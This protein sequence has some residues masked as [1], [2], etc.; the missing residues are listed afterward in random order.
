[1]SM[2]W[3]LPGMRNVGCEHN[4]GRLLHE[5]WLV[6]VEDVLGDCNQ[7][8]MLAQTARAQSSAKTDLRLDQWHDIITPLPKVF[9]G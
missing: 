2:S 4:L 5:Q 8:H 6:L 9:T 7:V 3:R 1:M